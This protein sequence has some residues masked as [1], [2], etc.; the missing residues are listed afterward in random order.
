[1]ASSSSKGMIFLETGN[2]IIE[3]MVTKR[4]DA[5]EGAKLEK[6]NDTVADFD[7]TSFRIQSTK[8][9]PTIVSV[10]LTIRCFEDLVSCG[11]NEVLEE[12][13]GPMLV[14]PRDGANVTLEFNTAEP[15]MPRDELIYKVANLRRAVLG[16]PFIRAF[17]A[18]AAGDA[19][20]I[21][22]AHVPF[23]PS[24]SFF[25]VPR[26]DRVLVVYSIEFEDVT[27]RAMARVIAQEFVEAQRTV[28]SAPP[29]TFSPRDVPA[30]L[31]ELTI[32][33][34]DHFVGFLSFGIFQQHVNTPA[35][36]ENAVSLL[37]GFRNYIHYHIKAAK[38]Y[39]HMRM[40]HRV[41]AMLQVL[42]R[43]MPEDKFTA[44]DRKLMSGKRFVRK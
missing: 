29:V 3:E 11:A 20:A 22:A 13:Y 17:K 33:T 24:E 39:L 41:N 43:A 38:S 35:K 37:S 2:K 26:P 4:F 8:E 25:V 15:P 5:E 44:K 23:R 30:E 28:S 32:P 7:D 12:Q 9:A 1:M 34:T 27:D 6:L 10:S 40:R 18:L 36:L 14:E 31:R 16:A 21:P 42:N 19:G